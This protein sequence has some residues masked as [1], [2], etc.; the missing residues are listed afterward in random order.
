MAVQY[1]EFSDFPGNIA[2]ILLIRFSPFVFAHLAEVCVADAF[3]QIAQV[4][5]I[6]PALITAIYSDLSLP[7]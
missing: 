5:K 3:P 6:F 7:V 4:S 1:F 2:F